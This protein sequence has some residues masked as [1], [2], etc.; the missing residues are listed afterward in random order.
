MAFMS[1]ERSALPWYCERFLDVFLSMGLAPF[2]EDGAI[3]EK[4]RKPI[5]LFISPGSVSARFPGEQGRFIKSRI[6]MTVVD[7]ALWSIIFTKMSE[8]AFFLAKLLA[9]ELPAKLDEVF[10]DAGTK[11]VP[12]CPRDISAHCSCANSEAICRHTAGVFFSMISQFEK[13]PFSL[14]TFRGRG[15]EQSLF[16]LR[17]LRPKVANCSSESHSLNYRPTNYKPSQALSA[18]VL[19]FWD[20]SKLLLELSYNIRADELPA[21]LLR[22]LDPLPVKEM[23]TETELALEDAYAKVARRAQALGLG[24]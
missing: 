16:Q 9:G 14:L 2:M 17:E 20:S 13:D 24:L 3:C 7:E 1:S 8:T 23:Q 18:T 5:D 12:D 4:K 11:L 10:R 15:R 6:S 19:N 21:S 22:R